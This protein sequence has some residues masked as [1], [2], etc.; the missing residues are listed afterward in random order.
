VRIKIIYT[1]TRETITVQPCENNI[2]NKNNEMGIT[3]KI[4]RK[5]ANGTCTR[6]QRSKKEKEQLAIN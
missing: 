4:S 2:Q 1:I 5:Q 3:S 6:K